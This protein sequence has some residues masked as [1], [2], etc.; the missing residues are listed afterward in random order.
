MLFSPLADAVGDEELDSAAVDASDEEDGLGVVLEV[1]S[2]DVAEPELLEPLALL[3]VN[4]GLLFPESPKTVTSRVKHRIQAVIAR[5]ALT[6]DN[7]IS[8]RVH[9]RNY[10]VDLTGCDIEPICQ[11]FIWDWG[12]VYMTGQISWIMADQD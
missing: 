9:V 4:S 1:G 5:I 10:N 6:D 2:V 3:I 7:I 12:S 8:V 11:R